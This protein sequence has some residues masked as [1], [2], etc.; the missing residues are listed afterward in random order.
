MGSTTWLT[1][2]RCQNPCRTGVARDCKTCHLLPPDGNRHPGLRELH[3][4]LR[5]VRRSVVH[6]GSGSRRCTRHTA[7]DRAAPVGRAS[8]GRPGESSRPRVACLHYAASACDDLAP[9]CLP[10]QLPSPSCAGTRP[11]GWRPNQ[12]RA[13]KWCRPLGESICPRPPSIKRSSLTLCAS[14]GASH[15]ETAQALLSNRQLPSHC[16]HFENCTCQYR[17]AAN[18]CAANDHRSSRQGVRRM[19]RFFGLFL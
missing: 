7:S 1:Q 9:C 5:D 10:G 15:G 19:Q 8:P 6:S 4:D 12:L 17:V 18:K 3:I 14:T 16:V 11:G 13:D 2:Q